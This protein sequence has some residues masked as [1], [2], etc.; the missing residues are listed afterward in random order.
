[1]LLLFVE[2]EFYT[3]QGILSTVDWQSLGVDRVEYAVDGK[4]GEELLSLR[5]DILLTDIR[6]PYRSGLELAEM[7][8]E[9][10]PGCEIIIL[11][12]YSDKEYLLK[13]ISLSTVAY[14]EKPVDIG[15]L[16]HAVSQA[17]ER[18]RKARR[19]QE[20]ES[21]EAPAH[22]LDGLPDCND[23]A[24]SHT[25]RIVLSHLM[26]HY[27]DPGLSLDSIAAYVHLNPAYLSD[28][29]KK[30][31]GHNLKRLITEVRM[32]KACSLLASTNLSVADI[33]AQ[34]GYRSANYFSRLFRQETGMTPLEY[35][36]SSDFDDQ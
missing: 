34:T 11:S 17:V 21:G 33:A 36:S 16:S 8:K 15:E 18:R 14:I 19:F 29:F 35:R 9:A 30:D 31:T 24:F 25:T 27:A 1:M 7:A 22:E 4:T 12:S 13:A 6:M 3:R 28:S 2:D 26:R 5:P 32:K 20:L 10:D 23:H